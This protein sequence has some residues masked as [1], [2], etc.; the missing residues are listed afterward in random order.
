MHTIIIQNDGWAVEALADESDKANAG[1][2]LEKELQ[3]C[4]F[5]KETRDNGR[6]TGE[7]RYEEQGHDK[8]ILVEAIVFKRHFSRAENTERDLV[9][10]RRN[11]FEGNQ[12]KK[13]AALYSF[14][15]KTEIDKR[16]FS[17]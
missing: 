5:I 10:F 17:C 14:N 15:L 3:G 11:R 9:Y 2:I 1:S 12:C 6:Y 7:I 16:Y 8:L 13:E 4:C